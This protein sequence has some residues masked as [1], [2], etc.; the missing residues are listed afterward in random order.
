MLSP[1]EEAISVFGIFGFTFLLRAKIGSETKFMLIFCLLP[2]SPNTNVSNLISVCRRPSSLSIAD[3]YDSPPNNELLPTY[4]TR[5]SR[6]L[7][8]SKP[9]RVLRF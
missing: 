2:E 4:D 1:V 5:V 7:L 6:R 3:R 9:A 8:P